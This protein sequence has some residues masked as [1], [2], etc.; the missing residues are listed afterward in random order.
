MAYVPCDGIPFTVTKNSTGPGT[1]SAALGGGMATCSV[2]DPFELPVYEC[3][4]ISCL[5][6]MFIAWVEKHVRMTD[7][8]IDD[9]SVPLTELWSR[10]RSK[11]SPP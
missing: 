6:P 3:S 2:A 11:L 7:T 5:M 4:R 1:S 9:R 8:T 10:K